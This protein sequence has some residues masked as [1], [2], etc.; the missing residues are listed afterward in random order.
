ML[1]EWMNELEAKRYREKN[2][3]P[4]GFWTIDLAISTSMTCSKNI[5]LVTCS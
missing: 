5:R 2:K 4:F 3:T 1:V